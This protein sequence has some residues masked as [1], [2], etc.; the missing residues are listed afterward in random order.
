V[1]LQCQYDSRTESF[2]PNKGRQN[3]AHQILPEEGKMHKQVYQKV[4]V[5][6]KV[7][8]AIVICFF[9]ICSSATGIIAMEHGEKKDD[10][11][12]HMAMQ[13]KQKGPAIEHPMMKPKMYSKAKRCT[14]CGMMINMWARTRH[15]FSHTEGDFTT[16]SI[17]CLADKVANSGEMVTDAQVALYLAPE[18]MI[19][20]GKAIYV[21]G[22]SAKG[23]M[24][25][26][27]KIAFAESSAAEKFVAEYGGKITD[28]DG[29]FKAAGMELSKSRMMIDKK[30]KKTGKIKE[31]GEKDTCVVCGM[32]PARYPK[33]NAQIW[34]KG[35]ETIHFCSTH[36]FVD[37]T[38]EPAKYVGKP[39]MTKMA[40]V[41]L[42]SDGMYESAFGPYYVVGSN[43]HGPMGMEALPFKS[44]KNAQT[45]VERNGGKIVSFAQLTP[46][47]VNG[48]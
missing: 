40:W 23:T 19:P 43:V 45:F 38:A 42:F 7:L 21:V 30:R 12:G 41:T 36:C 29:A 18:T 26:N 34:I 15:S 35:G 22:S 14:D 32:Y 24:T 48:E 37:F 11:H 25:M 8:G 16:C 6:K 27:S 47:V 31:P 13:G 20:V 33:H 4:G 39:V 9:L 10:G 44:K 2:Y 28:F 3:V 1:Q 17:R 5:G 46:A